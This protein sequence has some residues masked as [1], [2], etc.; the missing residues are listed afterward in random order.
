MRP[1]RLGFQKIVL[2]A[3]VLVLALGI[4][5]LTGNH[6]EGGVASG[7]Q[8]AVDA[9]S[10]AAESAWTWI[11]QTVSDSTAGSAGSQSTVGE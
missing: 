2:L 10:Q 6:I 3:E 1:G 8:S 11:S 4:L 9:A 7:V 5:L